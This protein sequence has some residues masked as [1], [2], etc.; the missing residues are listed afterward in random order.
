MTIYVRTSEM[1][2]NKLQ[3]HLL[4]EY[5][6]SLFEKP[7]NSELNALNDDMKTKINFISSYFDHDEDILSQ[8]QNIEL[9]DNQI[10]YTTKTNDKKFIIWYDYD[11]IHFKRCFEPHQICLFDDLT[12]EIDEFDS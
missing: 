9:K 6:H 3:H 11:S 1:I 2:Y 5:V 7:F 8:T 10:V 4:W 12:E